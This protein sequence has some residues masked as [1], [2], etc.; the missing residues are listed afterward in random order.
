MN[1]ATKRLLEIKALKLV[2]IKALKLVE[3]NKTLKQ[4]LNKALQQNH[5]RDNFKRDLEMKLQESVN[6]LLANTCKDLLQVP[7][8]LNQRLVMKLSF[9]CRA[10]VDL[11]T[12]VV[13]ENATDI[14]DN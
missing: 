5:K 6:K 4:Y 11:E 10:Y 8:K 3:F 9:V 1:L 13:T 2:G 7:C 12:A 14:K